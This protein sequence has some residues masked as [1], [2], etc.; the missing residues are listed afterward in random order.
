MNAKID[1]ESVADLQDVMAEKMSEV[2]ERQE[3]LA[4][5]TEQGKADLLNEIEE[6][7]A[8]TIA[9]EM[10]DMMPSIAPLV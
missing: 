10:E 6:F 3:I 7:E 9:D 5:V 8:D 4:D 2:N 1:V